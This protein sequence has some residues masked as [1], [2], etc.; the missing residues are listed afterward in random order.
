MR[1]GLGIG[2]SVL[3]GFLVTVALLAQFWAPGQLQK[4]PLDV[5][6]TTQLEGT[7]ELADGTG[8][9]DSS[10]VRAWS[11]TRT[12]SEASDGDVAVWKNSSCLVKDEGDI[13][14]CVSADD[15][16]ERLISASV[17]SFATD[18]VS[19]EAVNDPAYL[20]PGAE[21][22]VG[23]INKFPFGSEKTTYDYWDSILGGP[24]DA[25]Y[26]RTE[27]VDGLELY[28]YTVVIDDAEV[29]LAAGIDGTYSDNKEIWVEPVTG[30]IVNQIDQQER[31]KEDG[32]PLL[33]LDLAFTDD[34]VAKSVE[35]SKDNVDQLN[36]V[37][38]TLPLI[39]F[40]VGIPALLI[41]L[42]LVLAQR[43]KTA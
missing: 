18:R 3:G 23:L 14:A 35:E 33:I 27:E 32:D 42:A 39:G 36:L 12:D 15:S 7:V 29:E 26:D 25:T 34:Q 41:G 2:L 19:A 31:V 37:G 38:S 5:D 1:K 30:S 20:P 17:D 22:K 24:V 43:R 9:T 13:D 21:E 6:T 4:T 10:P 8:G 11:V 40:L 16:L 28:V